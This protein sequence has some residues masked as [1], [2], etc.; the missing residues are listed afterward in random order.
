MAEQL[1]PILGHTPSTMPEST[2]PSCS[3][4]DFRGAFAKGHTEEDVFNAFADIKALTGAHLVVV[5]AFRDMWGLGGD[6]NLAMVGPDGLLYE[7]PAGWSS[8][9]YDKGSE[10]PADSLAALQ[11]AEALDGRDRLIQVGA[12]NYTWQED[13]RAELG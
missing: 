10:V 4:E 1:F 7:A 3:L 8:F 13:L 11:P 6:S 2:T 9:L 5:W 12:Y